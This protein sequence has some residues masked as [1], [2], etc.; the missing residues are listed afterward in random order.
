MRKSM[1]IAVS[2]M[3]VLL[4]SMTAS[5]NGEIWSYDDESG[6]VQF[7][8]SDTG[9]GDDI[10]VV[11][12]TLDQSGDP[13]ILTLTVVGDITGEYGEDGED[14]YNSYVLG[15]DL[16]GDED[17][18]EINVKIMGIYYGEETY[19]TISSPTAIEPIGDDN[20]TISGSTFTAR[21]NRGYMGSFTSVL[22]FTGSLTQTMGINT[23][24]DYI[25]YN[26]GD[27]DKPYDDGSSG[28]DD[29]DDTTDDDTGDDTDDEEEE[30]DN[31]LCGSILLFPIGILLSSLI[32]I[33]TLFKIR[34]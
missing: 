33:F 21:I 14:G 16:D 25:N 22:D 29:D 23:G 7:T 19:I 3:A 6:D 24:F 32:A 5:G 10:D 20:Y 4:I 12:L 8:M 2:M 28:D 27:D 13:L 9:H 17:Y 30:T 31:E 11:S 34:K 18:A 15:L 1:L 26:F